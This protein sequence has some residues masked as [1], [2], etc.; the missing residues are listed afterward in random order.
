VIVTRNDF[1]KG[2]LAYVQRKLE[3]GLPQEGFEDELIVEAEKIVYENSRH[4]NNA[5]RQP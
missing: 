4:I 3:A 2:F 1:I 5:I